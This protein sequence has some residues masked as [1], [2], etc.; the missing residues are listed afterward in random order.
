[1]VRQ[2]TAGNIERIKKYMFLKNGA[3]YSILFLG[4][5][6]MLDA[7][8][9]EIPTWISPVATFIIVGYFFQRSWLANKLNS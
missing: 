7:F 5:I 8:G 9:L 4:F 1:V 2:L 6:M 3:M